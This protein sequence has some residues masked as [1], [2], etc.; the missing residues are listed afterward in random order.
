LTEHIR[1]LIVT[2][3][4]RN[5]SAPRAAG[6]SSRLR[7]AQADAGISTPD[8]AAAVKVH[9]KTVERWRRSDASASI[10]AARLVAL[11]AALDVDPTWLLVGD[12]E[13]VA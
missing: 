6:L 13:V 7:Q 8:L 1:S 2:P 9:P 10:P 12:H 4:T 3:V 5:T 11:A